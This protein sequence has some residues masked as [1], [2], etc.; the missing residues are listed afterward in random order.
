MKNILKNI[1]LVAS[2]L[3]VIGFSFGTIGVALADRVPITPSSL[4]VS[5]ITLSGLTAGSV[6]Y[7]GT[8]G[9]IS[10]NNSN[11]FWNNASTSLSIG[12]TTA[13]AFSGANPAALFIDTSSKTTEEGVDVFSSVNDFYELNVINKSAGANAQGC[14]TGTND[15]GTVTSGFVS[16]CANSSAFNNPQAYN[17]GGA[18]DTSIMGF[19]TGD[20][21]IVNATATRSMYFLTGGSATSTF[22]RMSI[23]GAGLVGIASSTPSYQLTVASGTIFSL[24]KNL[25]T[26]TS[27][28]IDWKSGNQQLAR[29]GTAAVTM[30]LSN[31]LQGGTLRLIVCNPPT[32]T[33]GTI[34][35][36]PAP[37][38]SG[39]TAPSQTTTANHCD[40]WSFIA[41]QATSSASSLIFGSQSPNF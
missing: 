24:E 12:T 5:S 4:T 30:T 29:I 38:W 23:S 19:S 39:G 11:L 22:T 14:V 27:M 6:P 15:T 32:G 26:S 1:L 18:G 28:T 34:T 7:V 2:V 9:L 41:T 21:E 35:W 37:Y 36:S 16:I 33:A 25:A 20:F 17:T 31:Y 3:G 8:A 13:N 10:Q 40:V